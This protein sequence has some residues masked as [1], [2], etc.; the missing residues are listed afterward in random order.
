MNLKRMKQAGWLLVAIAVICSFTLWGQRL[1]SEADYKNVQMLVNYNDI[2]ALA[3]GNDLSQEELAAELQQRGV[4]AVLYKELSLGDLANNGQVALQ[5]GGTIQNTNF[6]SQV[7]DA[8]PINEATLYVAIL[9]P[10][11]AEQVQKHALLKI[12]GS[13]YYP[14]QVPV[15]TV[16]VMVPTGDVEVSNIMTKVKDIGVG[17][18]QAGI[19]RMAA[20]G[21]AAVPQLRSWDNPTDEALRAV[22]DEIKAMPNLAYLLFNDKELPGY[23]D[24]VRTIADLLKDS[25]GNT[26]VTIGSI[27][28]SDQK[29]L[30]QLGVLLNKDLI[31]LH[32]I[33]NGEMSKF[34]PDTALDRWMLAARE[35]NM[36][37]LLVRFFD[38]TSPGTA[39]QQNLDY[40]ESIQTGLLESGFQLDQPYEKPNSIDAGNIILYLIGIGVA[41][42]V[43]LVLLE[44][45]LPKLGLLA[46]IL[47]TVCWIGLLHVSPVLAK[48]LMA[49][50]SVITFPILSCLIMM[51]PQKRSIGRSVV[52]LLILCALSYIGAVL[53]VGLL[54]DVLFMLKL[55]QFIG[56]KIA[57][58]IP[59]VV[60]PFI[61]YIW[62]TEKPLQ[63]VKQLLDKALDYKWAAL[64]AIVAVAGFIYISRTG[65]TTAELSAAEAGMRNFLND[66]LGVRP[67]SKEFLIGYP[68]TL[69][70]FWLGASS[71]NWILTIPAVIGQVSLVNTYA[72]IHTALLISLQR[73]FNGLV[74]GIVIGLLLILAVQLLIK[75]Y[76]RLEEKEGLR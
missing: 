53:M 60:V 4:S 10:S 7:S 38:I 41:A 61:L 72:H 2:I 16:P 37:S 8:L 5:L 69:L 34:E 30:T 64:A 73:S 54:A 9:D 48:K 45:R 14:G 71:R 19:E 62:N 44:M 39:L 12:A 65:N 56:V 35:R 59:I 63:T 75:L 58:V 6:Y 68:L 42:G 36:R 3:N 32:T 55:D 11:I 47:G 18:N 49:L 29:G 46:L 27:E 28:F 76:H 51:K 67:R 74:L 17:F 22:T 13:A 26:L 15:I 70:L 23:P 40:L 66:V 31:R 33:S 20:V 43:M 24:S 50:L 1:S 21:F 52:A 57:H 25:E